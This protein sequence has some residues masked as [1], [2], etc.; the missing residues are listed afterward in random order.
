MNAHAQI[1]TATDR[2]EGNSTMAPEI[3]LKVVPVEGE[4][5]LLRVTVYLCGKTGE[6]GEPSDRQD[7]I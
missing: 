4:L 7:D 6:T 2:Q 5:G 1:M 3:L